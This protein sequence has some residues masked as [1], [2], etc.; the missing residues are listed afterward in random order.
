MKLVSSLS[1]LLTIA[2]MYKASVSVLYYNYCYLGDNTFVVHI[3]VL[4]FKVF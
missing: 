3:P 4:W 1:S 2:I